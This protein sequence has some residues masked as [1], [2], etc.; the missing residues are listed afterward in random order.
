MLDAGNRRAWRAWLKKN[1]ASEKEIWLVFWKKHTG[2]T[3]ISHNEAAEEPLCFGWIDSTVRRLD[4]DR[5]AQRFSPRRPRTPFS[6][7][8][9]A[10]LRHLIKEGKVTPGVLAHLGDLTEEEFA[11]RLRHFLR[12]TTRNRLF[13]SGGIEK[14]YGQA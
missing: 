8:N 11:K 3:S 1:A 7:A 14:H 13:G 9:K 12:I 5:Y 4:D 6:Q 10:R 2:K